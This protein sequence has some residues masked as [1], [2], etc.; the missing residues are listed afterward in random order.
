MLIFGWGPFPALGVA[1]SG[2][3]LITSFGIAS[4]V[5]FFY[6]RSDKSLVKLAFGGAKY[7]W[8]LFREFLS[9]GV[10][11]MI[12]VGITNF[13][14]VVLTAVAGRLGQQAQI[15]YALGA[16]LEYI[17]I[18]L[19]FVFGTALVAMVGT[20]W[21]AKQYQRARRI[22]W[23]GGAIAAAA[24]GAV[25]VFFALFPALWMEL[26]TEQEEVLRVGTLYLHIAAPAYAAY[27]FG[28][29]LYFSSQ[30]FGKPLRAV[31]ANV[32]R[33]LLSAGGGLTAV[34]WL[35]AG[36]PAMFLGIASGFVL[37]AALNAWILRRTADPSA[38]SRRC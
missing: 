33:L 19:A 14:V 31:L 8:E 32:A 15:G 25:G 18:P 13:T 30:G 12:N 2:W 21:G 23:A 11:G 1:G 20:N 38:R 35:G 36:P 9:V 6:L 17:I 27:G 16:R 26:F 29:A 7:R 28:Q 24:C 3:G 5:V 10:P 22:A 37:Y 34:L 4:I